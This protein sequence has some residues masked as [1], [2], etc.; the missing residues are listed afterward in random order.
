MTDLPRRKHTEVLQDHVPLQARHVLD[1]GC[2]DGAL[3]RFMARHGA[4]ATGVE[5]SDEALS[6]AQA[7]DPAGGETY[8]QGEA[9]ALPLPDESFDTVTFFNSLHHVPTCE[10]AEALRESH[11]V[12]RPG[13]LLYVAEPLA[14]GPLFELLKPIEDETGVRAAAYREVQAATHANSFEAVAEFF[15]DAPIRYLDFADARSR[16]EAVDPRRRQKVQALEGEL[17]AAFDRL[18]EVVD[19]AV[20]FHQPMRVNILRSRKR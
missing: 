17:A 19:G 9:K 5:I 8:L 15:Y 13:C 1:V 20:L 4:H 7:H 3:V 16:F 6:R 11:R 18:G 2:G 14:D 10:I 12:L